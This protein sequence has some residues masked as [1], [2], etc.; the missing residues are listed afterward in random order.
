LA[1]EEKLQRALLA[2][3]FLPGF[4]AA[5]KLL[6]QQ[7]FDLRSKIKAEIEAAQAKARGDGAPPADPPIVTIARDM[8]KKLAKL[9]GLNLIQKITT[10]ANAYLPGNSISQKD[11]AD[12]EDALG[13]FNF[14]L[15]FK[16]VTPG[17]DSRAQDFNAA[18][19]TGTM[20]AQDAYDALSALVTGIDDQWLTSVKMLAASLVAAQLAFTLITPF[21]WLAP[22]LLEFAMIENDLGLP[23]LIDRAKQAVRAFEV[24]LQQPPAPTN[25]NNDNGQKLMPPPQLFSL[26]E[27]SLADAEF[28]K[29]ALHLEANRVYYLNSL[30]AQQDV[31]LRYETLVAL[32]VQSFV[33]NRLL[34]F[35]GRRA[36]FPLLVQNLEAEARTYLKEELTETLSDQL[37]ELEPAVEDVTLPTSGLHMEPVLGQCDA[38]EPYLVATRDNEIA[39]AQ[40]QLALAQARTAQVGIENSRR[41]LRLDDGDLSSP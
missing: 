27:L 6:A 40:A 38:L 37:V 34:G 13:C 4:D 22:V 10:L 23:A 19:P 32:G 15:K 11:R 41:Q 1:Q 25:S 24:T 14:W 35:L 12:A 39:A 31:N 18:I 30:F 26:Q 9:I 17:I 8:Q 3:N 21:P 5:K 20:T 33:E 36:I 7:Y 28:R 2:P 16:T 29:L